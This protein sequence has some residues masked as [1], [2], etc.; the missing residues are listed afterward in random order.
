[1]GFAE[2]KLHSVVEQEDNRG[3]ARDQPGSVAGQQRDAGEEQP[4]IALQVGEWSPPITE[5]PWGELGC[6]R[7]VYGLRA[8][9]VDKLEGAG[10]SSEKRWQTGTSVLRQEVQSLQGLF[11]EV[12]GLCRRAAA[13]LEL[14]W[15]FSIHPNVVSA[16]R[17]ISKGAEHYRMATPRLRKARGCPC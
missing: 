12:L 3:R 5:P 7:M 4:G 13:S 10:P 14:G 6:R 9:W 11:F 16:P 17:S 15:R 1:M 8:P 2:G